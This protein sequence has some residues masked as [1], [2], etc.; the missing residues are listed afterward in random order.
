MP[1]RRAAGGAV[2]CQDRHVSEVLTSEAAASLDAEAFR[3]YHL[4][5]LLLL[6]PL[7]WIG[8]RYLGWS[9]SRRV[10]VPATA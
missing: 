4:S 5:D 1:V 9:E 10:V 8:F 6:V 2:W 3:V 7:A